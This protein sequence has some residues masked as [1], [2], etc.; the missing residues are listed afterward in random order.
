[1]TGKLAN[2]LRGLKRHGPVTVIDG[3]DD[4]GPMKLYAFCKRQFPYFSKK[5]LIDC[6]LTGSILVNGDKIRCGHDDES[7]RLVAG[8]VIE[9][10]IDVDA[11]DARVVEATELSIL[12]IQSGFAVIS[13][14]CGIS[15]AFDKELDKALKA[16]LWDGKR[17]QECQLLYHLEKGFSGICIVAETAEHLSKLRALACGSYLIDND[18][19]ALCDSNTDSTCPKNDQNKSIMDQSTAD[20][21]ISFLGDGSKERDTAQQR[22]T[23]FLELTH[24]CIVCGKVGEVGETVFIESGH[25]FYPVSKRPFRYFI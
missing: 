24:R 25:S 3:S 17:K 13:K 12:H 19:A 2:K 16:K 18:D 15:A 8:D 10:Q 14:P 7:R 22:L 11:A 6:F 21:Q 9:I 23:P 20:L 4:S 5:C 1:M